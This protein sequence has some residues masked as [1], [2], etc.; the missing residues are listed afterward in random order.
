MAE[1]FLAEIRIF[2]FNFA[3]HGWAFCNGQIMPI[4]QNTALFSLL[5]VTYGG[6][7]T[8]NFG[9]PNLQGNVPVHAGQGPTT[10]DYALGEA[11]GTTQVNLLQ[12]QIPVHTHALN[13]SSFEG[14]EAS[15]K[16]QYAAGF[17]GVG[18]YAPAASPN[19]MMAPTMLGIAGGSQAHTNMMPY[20]A[21]NF[22]I[23]LS[24]VF[25]QR[26]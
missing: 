26:P 13:M 18:L 3:P 23:A 16:D 15:P 7:G 17:P 22:C 19:T 21:L 1:P 6:N 4:S 9:L 2:G 25:P 12:T 8:S 20:L 11:G 5:G 24:G 14:T 10:S